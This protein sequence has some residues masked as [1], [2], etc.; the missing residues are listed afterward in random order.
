MT[1]AARHA[2]LL[3]TSRITYVETYAALAR[4]RRLGRVR[5]PDH[6]RIASAFEALWRDIAVLAVDEPVV[7]RAARLADGHVLRGYDATQLAS[8]LELAQHGEVL[9]SSWDDDLNAAARHE[10]LRLAPA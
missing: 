4:M 8:A 7:E 10:G 3:A 6:G 1:A 2:A 9:F 5:G